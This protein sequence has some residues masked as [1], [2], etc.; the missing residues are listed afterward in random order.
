MHESMQPDRK[1]FKRP[2]NSRAFLAAN[3]PDRSV[4]SLAAR[5]PR[6]PILCPSLSVAAVWIRFM[7]FAMQIAIAVYWA[8]ALFLG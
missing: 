8:R 4:G 6:R 3:R 7:A 2:S 5:R 1:V